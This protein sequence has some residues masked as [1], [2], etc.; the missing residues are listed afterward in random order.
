M[1]KIAQLQKSQFNNKRK[2]NL[3]KKKKKDPLIIKVLTTQKE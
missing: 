3:I 1:L 2:Y